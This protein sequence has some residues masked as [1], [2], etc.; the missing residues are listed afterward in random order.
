MT[1]TL[2][3][4]ARI[5]FVADAPPGA[6][7]PMKMKSILLPSAFIWLIWVAIDWSLFMNVASPASLPPSLPHEYLKFSKNVFE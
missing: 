2:M 6:Y 7:D 1:G 4:A 5:C 3:P